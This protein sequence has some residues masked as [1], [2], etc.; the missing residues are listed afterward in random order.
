[1]PFLCSIAPSSQSWLCEPTTLVALDSLGA[2]FS[3]LVSSLVVDL[4]H[5]PAHSPTIL[6]CIPSLFQWALRPIWC[7]ASRRFTTCAF[8]NRCFS[9]PFRDGW[10]GSSG[11]GGVNGPLFFLPGISLVCSSLAF[12]PT[13][14][15]FFTQ[16]SRLD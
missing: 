3:C 15:L 10:S 4:T 14:L 6:V 9:S 16:V 13:R 2:R 5:P 8:T 11:S 12:N 7:R 1:M